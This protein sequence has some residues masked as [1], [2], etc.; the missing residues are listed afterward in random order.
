VRDEGRD[1][2]GFGIV[3]LEAALAGLPVI[4]GRSGGA[5]E[6]IVD[7]KT[8]RLVDPIRVDDLVHAIR[9]LMENAPL[10]HQMGEA[11]RLRALEA[12]RWEDRWERLRSWL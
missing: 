10:C 11:G 2:E 5:P 1:V 3:Y 12:Y 9:A 4:A 6:A 7:G 8:G